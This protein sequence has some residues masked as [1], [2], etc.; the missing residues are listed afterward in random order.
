VEYLGE[1]IDAC[2]SISRD[3]EILCDGCDR[4]MSDRTLPAHEPIPRV[5]NF[6]WRFDD[7]P[8]ATA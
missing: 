1:L 7:K 8:Y 3:V 6:Q 4:A 5:A 2:D